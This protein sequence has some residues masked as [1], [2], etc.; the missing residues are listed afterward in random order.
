[1]PVDTGP[2]LLIFI[3]PFFYCIDHTFSSCDIHVYSMFIY[4][5]MYLFIRFLLGGEKKIYPINLYDSAGDHLGLS[6]GW[7]G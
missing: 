1:M 5:A 2:L 3:Y 6:V 4:L 7:G